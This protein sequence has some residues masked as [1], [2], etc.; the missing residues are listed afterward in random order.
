MQGYLFTCWG[1]LSLVLWWQ[2]KI[3]CVHLALSQNPSRGTLTA[4]EHKTKMWLLPL[5]SLRPETR[6]CQLNAMVMPVCREV[7]WMYKLKEAMRERHCNLAVT[8]GREIN[9][10]L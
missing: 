7:M 8:H 9:P 1:S 6:L 2:N 5:L 10:T 4:E 3:M